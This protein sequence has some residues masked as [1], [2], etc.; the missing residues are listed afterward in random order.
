MIIDGEQGTI[1]DS[2]RFIELFNIDTKNNHF[3]FLLD[4]EYLSHIEVLEF[5]T[6]LSYI[7]PNNLDRNLSFVDLA[8]SMVNSKEKHFMFSSLR[9]T[10]MKNFMD[11]QPSEFD[12]HKLF[13]SNYKKVIDG[14]LKIVK[15]KNNI[16]HIPDFWLSDGCEYIP[17]EIK[18][19]D[20]NEFSLRQ[21]KRYM[22]FY[23]CKKGLAVAEKLNC[24]LPDGIY[25]IDYKTLEA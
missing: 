17:V 21:L 23:K 1:M 10:V 3:V 22:N 2:E 25:F 9:S 16:K 8:E 7:E 6:R 14:E 5:A 20:F 18:L 24:T 15:R 12:I 13:E 11:S 19:H 4:K